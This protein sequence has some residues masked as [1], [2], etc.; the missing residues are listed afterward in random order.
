[1]PLSPGYTAERKS[2]KNNPKIFPLETV[3]AGKRMFK[4]FVGVPEETEIDVE[5]LPERLFVT[6]LL[7]FLSFT[8]PALILSTFIGDIFDST[9]PQNS[10]NPV[11]DEFKLIT[12]K[13]LGRFRFKE[14]G[15]RLI[16]E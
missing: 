10:W 9:Y 5:K 11:L 1:M 2:L 7:P 14:G 12:S 8:F 16:L 15:F 13:K 3:V 4:F 6:P